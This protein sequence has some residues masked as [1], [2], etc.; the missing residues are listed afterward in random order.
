MLEEYIVVLILGLL[1]ISETRGAI[2]YGLGMNLNIFAVFLISV[3]ANILTVPV[4]FWILKKWR[5]LD[6]AKKIFGKR[7]F[8]KIERNRER[9]EKWEELSLFAFVAIP[10]PFT[11]AWTGAFIATLL[12]MDKKKAF[13]VI[14]LGVIFAALVTLAVS[15]GLISGFQF[16]NNL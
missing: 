9:L 2:I 3:G 6:I 1:P 10:A 4:I 11:G 7:I 5:F 16:L 14:S 12:E 15:L 13:L 8:N